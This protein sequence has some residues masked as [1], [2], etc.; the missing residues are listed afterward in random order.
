MNSFSLYN[1]I[2]FL[3]VISIVISISIIAWFGFNNTSK[4]YTELAEETS[5]QY[6]NSLK[7]SIEGR[8]SNIPKDVIFIS[9]FYALRKLLT[10]DRLNEKTKLKKWKGIFTNALVDFLHTKKDYYKARILD[11]D[12]NEVV[13]VHYL[14]DKDETIVLTD[15]MLQNKKN[16]P[17]FTKA[18]SLKKGE[19]HISS[20]NL[21]ME[22]SKVLKPYIPV[23]RYVTPIVGE[24][25][26]VMAFIVVSA[27]AHE[28]LGT[29]Q[30]QTDLDSEKSILYYLI[31]KNGDYFYHDKKIKRWNAQL[32]NGHNFNSDHFNIKEHMQEKEY[33]SLFL[34]EKIYSFHKVHPYAEHRDNFWY[35]VS[36]IDDSVA[37]A[38]LDSFK[39]IFL[40]VVLLI[41]LFSFVVVRYFI[42]KV[43]TPLTSVTN[44]LL[45]LSR[46]EI[47]K[48]DIVY[49]QN[50][51]IGKIVRSTQKV[52]SSIERIT[53]QAN[54][55]AGGD[56]SKEIKL[57]G[58]NDTLGIAINSM[59]TRLQEIEE[60]AK[61]LSEGNYETDIIA[62]SSQDK[63]GIA[64]LDM[65]SYLESV[66]KVAETVAK[67]EIE[68]P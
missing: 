67:G 23:I 8:L 16:R 48:V 45:A 61:N 54:L 29:L 24:N 27:Y 25:G 47:K 10:W 4:A 55:V 36:S 42:S 65:I 64:L 37:L 12:G 63:L 40:V 35:I 43:T 9:N 41:I 51:E 56:L 21:N 15:A 38:K 14:S 18:K 49:P 1:K 33:G 52:I 62:K 3:F 50:D 34:N 44:Q 26:N 22:N 46:G 5:Y 31:D 6:S 20:M 28:L 57:L 19:F 39:T 13:N 58:E 59:T 2:F 32:G 30:K 60:L 66:T 17:Y 11:L 53:K 68:V 7:S